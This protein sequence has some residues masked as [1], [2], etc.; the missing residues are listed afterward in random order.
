MF[1]TIDK[2]V[3]AEIV[4]KKS[5]FIANIF[6]VETVEEA[7]EKVKE[8]KKKHYDARHNCYAFSIFSKE[9]IVNRFSD[10]GEPSGTAGSP[11]LNI[12]NSKG[13][14]NA[15]VIVT[16]YFGGILLGTGGL[17]RAYTGAMQ[18]ALK[19]IQEVTKDTGLEVCLETSYPD[20]E[21]MKYYLK[22]NNIDNVN[23]EFSENVNV[24]VDIT[25]EKY[26]NLLETKNDLNFKII[27]EK[28]IKEKYIVIEN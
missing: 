4:E 10:D 14:V 3:Q 16:R 12:L 15:V 11:M 13:I 19:E 6:Y 20:L 27:S 26:K 28:I 18:E 22:Q 9:G 17:V 24:Y 8:I 7:E 25:E 2:D 21:K 23:T 5:K 1:K